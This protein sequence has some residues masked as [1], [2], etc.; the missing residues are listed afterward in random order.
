MLSDKKIKRMMQND[1]AKVSRN[2]ILLSL[3][4]DMFVACCEEILYSFWVSVRSR[5]FYLLE[6][7]LYS[8]LVTRYRIDASRK[9]LAVAI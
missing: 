6:E 7:R 2:R 8:L 5:N 9:W 4:T 3:E 1:R